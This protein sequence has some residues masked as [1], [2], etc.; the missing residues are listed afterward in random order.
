MGCNSCRSACGD[1][2]EGGVTFRRA[3]RPAVPAARSAPVIGTE[4]RGNLDGM[5]AVA[6]LG[7]DPNSAA[8]SVDSK[9][10][11]PE[12]GSDPNSAGRRD[13]SSRVFSAASA[14]AASDCSYLI[15]NNRLLDPISKPCAETRRM[16]VRAQFGEASSTNS[17]AVGRIGIRP[18]FCCAAPD[19]EAAA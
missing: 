6:D 7:S 1:C 17:T 15:D 8:R 13:N 4:S 10:S 11:F 14:Y 19:F 18:Q 16:G 3:V 5:H 12:L 9:R 2:S